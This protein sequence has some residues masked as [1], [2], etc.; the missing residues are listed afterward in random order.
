MAYQFTF[1]E[2]LGLYLAVDGESIIELGDDE[3]EAL[4][5]FALRSHLDNWISTIG[6]CH[7]NTF[8]VDRRT[9]Y[10]GTGPEEAKSRVFALREALNKVE[11]LGSPPVRPETSVGN[12]DVV[13]LAGAGYYTLKHALQIYAARDIEA[14]PDILNTL[15]FLLTPN[16]NLVIHE[17]VREAW[18]GVEIKDRRQPFYTNS[19]EY[20]VL[21]DEEADQAWDDELERYIDD[22]LDIP[23]NVKP[24]FDREKWKSDARG[25]G[26]G[27]AL[28]GYDGCENRV[29]FG[30]GLDGKTEFYIYR[31]N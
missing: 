27:H 20:L 11:M 21:T 18:A 26:R 3:D 30:Y 7:G 25:D 12:W 31:T 19:G 28:S 16:Y 24:Y 2:E 29:V 17:T 9:E 8:E 23:D 6:K 22:C 15:Y 14:G 10:R 4:R 13:Q 1:D 5:V